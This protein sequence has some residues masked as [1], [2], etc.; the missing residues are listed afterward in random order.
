MI[1]AWGVLRLGGQ[2]VEWPFS[3]IGAYSSRAIASFWDTRGLAP[4]IRPRYHLFNPASEPVE[5]TL[6]VGGSEAVLPTERRKLG[7][8]ESVALTPAA[9]GSAGWLRIQ[10]D[11]EPL[12]LVAMGLLTG[13]AAADGGAAPFLATLPLFLREP[14]GEATDYHALRLPL[15]SRDRIRGGLA[16][17]QG[18]SEPGRPGVARTVLSLHNAGL[19]EQVLRIEL[20]SF[21]T[22][23]PIDS[24]EQPLAPG[25]IVNLDPT[26]RLRGGMDAGTLAAEVRLVLRGGTDAVRPWAVSLSPAG[27]VLDVRFLRAQEAHPTSLYALPSLEQ[28]EIVDTLVNLGEQPTTILGQIFWEGGSYSLP[29]IRIAPG[30]SHQLDI[31]EVARLQVPD[32]LGR[33]LDPGYQRGY[34]QWVTQ[35]G[36]GKILD[37]IELRRRQGWDVFGF[38]YNT[39]CESRPVGDLI[40]GSVVLDFGVPGSFVASEY[41]F[42]CSSILG[43]YDAFITDL[44]YA[45]PLSW[46]GE[47]ASAS[48]DTYQIASFEGLG[49][50]VVNDPFDGCIPQYVNYGD[51]GPATAD[52]CRQE[53]HPGY[54]PAPGCQ[55]QSDNCS[56]CYECCDKERDVADCQCNGSAPCEQLAKAACGTCKQSCFGHFL[57]SCSSQQT[58]CN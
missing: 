57:D 54:N 13:Q 51:E 15:V 24:F 21:D 33:T 14:S 28:F 26:Q 35:L 58:T 41:I 29:P 56:D 37:R 4:G 34:L 32:N 44:D 11:G 49:Q 6:T 31:E 9:P 18:S 3:R 45:S 30:H 47:T 52:A 38:K 25:E 16:L 46:N 39:C 27:E 20:E 36:S 19:D 17:R 22:G 2:Y 1:E 55:S 42:T 7:P 48:D 8:R 40:P 50:E 5:Y 23:A 53:H 12:S 10:Q 43:P